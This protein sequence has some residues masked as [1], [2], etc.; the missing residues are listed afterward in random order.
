MP[1]GFSYEK[2]GREG[3]TP[4]TEYIEATLRSFSFAA[5]EKPVFV[6]EASSS[7]HIQLFEEPLK[8]FVET[9]KN[10]QGAIDPH[11]YT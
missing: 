8:T 11:P 7:M 5:K 1:L 2:L 4:L 10:G 3:I 6:R 9:I